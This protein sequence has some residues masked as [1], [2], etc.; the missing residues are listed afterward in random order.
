MSQRS[1]AER[2]FIDMVAFLQAPT[3]DGSKRMLQSHPELMNDSGRQML[4]SMISDRETVAW[5]YPCIDRAHSDVL[6]QVHYVVLGRCRQIGVWEAFA[7]LGQ[8]IGP[9]E[10]DAEKMKA[11]LPLSAFL[12]AAG[13]DEALS[14]LREYPGLAVMTTA[15]LLDRLIAAARERGDLTT[16]RRLAERRR[17]MDRLGAGAFRDA[18]AQPVNAWVVAILAVL[19]AAVVAAAAAAVLMRGG[20]VD[21]SESNRP[22]SGAAP[23]AEVT[24][25]TSPPGGWCL[26]DRRSQGDRWSDPTATADNGGR[27][28]SRSVV[29]YLA[30]TAY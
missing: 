15:I 10:W 27:R 26:G 18:P 1:G 2:M 4:R 23:T 6:I 19:G 8:Q 24:A 12:N 9:V 25:R 13:Q 17:L 21:R 22:A 29:I 16:R 28:Q 5:T 30:C 7:E 11:L 20:G 14:V 3:W